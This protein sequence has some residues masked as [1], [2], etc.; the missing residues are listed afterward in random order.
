MSYPIAPWD[1]RGHGVQTLH[2][3]SAASVRPLVPKELEIVSV[4]P[5]KTL[6]VVAF[7][8]YGPGSVLEYD[9]LIVAPAVVKR[10]GKVGVWVSHIYVDHPDS[11]AGGREIWGVP[12]QLANFHWRDEGKTRTVTAAM[13]GVTLCT[14]TTGR[15]LWLLRKRIDFPSYSRLGGDLL[16]FVGETRSKVG[17]TR[18]RNDVPAESPFAAIPLSKPIVAAW[19]KEMQLICHAPVVV[20]SIAPAAMEYSR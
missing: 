5:G 17:L 2:L 6:A 4:L 3:V 1:L 10:A 11:V 15:R 9:E 20:G 19:L 12:K 18:G 8:H 7:A 16:R 14:M 13:D